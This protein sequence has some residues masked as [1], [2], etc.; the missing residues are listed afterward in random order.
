M[1]RF[2]ERENKNNLKKDATQTKISVLINSRSE[3]N[4]GEALCSV[5]KYSRVSQFAE[6]S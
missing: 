4:N 1:K 6:I 5:K 2:Q 3:T